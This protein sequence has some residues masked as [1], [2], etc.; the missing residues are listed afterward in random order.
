MTAQC[1]RKKCNGLTWS[2]IWKGAKKGF[3]YGGESGSG[4]RQTNETGPSKWRSGRYRSDVGRSSVK[5]LPFRRTIHRC[6]DSNCES[7]N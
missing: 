5:D 3:G 2:L 7:G 4:F 1:W 6:S